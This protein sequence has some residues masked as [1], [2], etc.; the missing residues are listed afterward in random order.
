L[1]YQ[2]NP[3]ENVE[4]KTNSKPACLIKDQDDQRQK[5]EKRKKESPL[6]GGKKTD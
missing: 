4:S 6:R 1:N 3:K 5:G 2:S